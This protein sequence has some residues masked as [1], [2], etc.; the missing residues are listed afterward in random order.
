MRTTAWSRLKI[1]SNSLWTRS[2][3]LF[4]RSIRN[5]ATIKTVSLNICTTRTCSLKKSTDC[6]L[7]VPTSQ[8]RLKCDFRQNKQLLC[9]VPSVSSRQA[10]NQWALLVEGLDLRR[11]YKTRKRI[12]EPKRILE[13]RR[14][15][16][17]TQNHNLKL[18]TT[19]LQLL[20][21]RTKSR[22]A[23][24]SIC[25]TMIFW[26]TVCFARSLTTLKK[27]MASLS[28]TSASKLA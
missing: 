6:K 24:E 3:K 15:I 22:M 7:K 11:T 28:H 23:M 26:L 17:K 13:R 25:V 8:V 10:A 19:S 14:Q 2:N 21:E 18:Y 4:R 16:K 5:V 12:G 27:L 1:Q 9:L 20:S